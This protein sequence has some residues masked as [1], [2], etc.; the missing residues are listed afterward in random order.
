MRCSHGKEPIP[1]R[2]RKIFI[3]LYR[4]FEECWAKHQES[5]PKEIENFISPSAEKGAANDNLLCCY[6]LSFFHYHCISAYQCMLE[7][8]SLA[9]LRCL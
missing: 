6:Q 9:S 7:A 8:V 3:S 2:S 4:L 1:L 5:Q